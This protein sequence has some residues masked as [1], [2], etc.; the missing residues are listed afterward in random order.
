MIER[1][2]AMMKD[3]NKMKTNIQK[4]DDTPA[5]KIY[6]IIMLCNFLGAFQIKHND[7]VV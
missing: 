2:N 6:I 1:Y 4:S 5:L 7:L 3:S